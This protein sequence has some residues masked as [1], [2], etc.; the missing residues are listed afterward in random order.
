MRRTRRL[1]AVAVVAVA[2]ASAAGA[3]LV[4]RVAA[5]VNTEVVA[6]SEVEARAEAELQRTRAL[7]PAERAKVRQ[8]I[9]DQAL[10]VVIGEKLLEAQLRELNIDVAPQEIQASIDELRKQN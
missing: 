9:L 8:Q 1:Q 3:E 6:L 7:P 2:L 5:V 10:E 4:D